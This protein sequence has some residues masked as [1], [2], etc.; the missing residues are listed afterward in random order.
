MNPSTSACSR[1]SSVKVTGLA[2]SVGA[3]WW[4][5]RAAGPG[6]SLLASSPAWCHIDPLPVLGRDHDEE[7]IWDEGEEDD[8][9]KDDQHRAAW[10]LEAREA[11]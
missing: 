7:E 5:A 8:D 6:A 11:S 4:A 1:I 2:Y 3:A 10:V 9:R